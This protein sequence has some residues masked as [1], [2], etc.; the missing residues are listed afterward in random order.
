MPLT[1]IPLPNESE[2]R[3]AGESAE[4]RATLKKKIQAAY[5]RR[6]SALAIV[7][8]PGQ[9]K[10]KRAELHRQLEAP[11]VRTFEEK[12]QLR[13]HEH[14]TEQEQLAAEPAAEEAAAEVR[15]LDAE[16]AN[17]Q[18]TLD[19]VERQ[20]FDRQTVA[21]VADLI[22]P[23]TAAV[24]ASQV[25]DEHLES[26]RS[27]GY[28]LPALGVFVERHPSASRTSLRSDDVKVYLQ[29]LLAGLDPKFAESLPDDHP[30]KTKL[31]ASANGAGVAGLALRW[32]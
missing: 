32:G 7:S 15:S 21:L 28:R 12:E 19:G 4:Q 23:W 14:D 27:R 24:Q 18:S 5:T 9:L 10:H 17:L 11:A 8:K 1:F 3:I 20:L 30:A 22:Q 29:F 13:K 6:N 25:L 2:I 26:G 31:E 16:I